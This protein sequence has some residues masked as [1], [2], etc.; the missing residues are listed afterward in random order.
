M[1]DEP[2][3]PVKFQTSTN[4]DAFLIYSMSTAIFVEVHESKQPEA[5]YA[6]RDATG[7]YDAMEKKFFL[8]TINA[9]GELVIGEET[10]VEGW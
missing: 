7:M 3:Q 6:I 4:N 2:L 1:T 9:D 8:G 5:F 10:T